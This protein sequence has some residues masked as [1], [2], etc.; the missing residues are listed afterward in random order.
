MEKTLKHL[1]FIQ[2]VINRFN[3]NS[4]LIKGWA[5]TLASAL[6]ALAAKDANQDFIKVIYVSIPAFWLLDAYYLSQERQFRELY[7]AVRLKTEAS[8]DF[9]MNAKAYANGWK[10]WFGSLWAPTNLIFYILLAALPAIINAL[11]QKI[12]TSI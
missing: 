8:I 10:T 7:D 9:S 6:F 5:V 11:F 2:A 4:F 12:A 1:E 3:G